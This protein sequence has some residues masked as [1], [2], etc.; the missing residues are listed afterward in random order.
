MVSDAMSS[1]WANFVKSG[2]PNGTG[3]PEWPKYDNPD[4]YQVMHLRWHWQP[5]CARH[6][7]PA[8]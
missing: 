1:Y 4:H 5:R 6:A 8:L 7:A 3:L 2:N